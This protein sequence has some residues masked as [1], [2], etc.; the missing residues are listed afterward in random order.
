MYPLC[1]FYCDIKE[2]DS[3]CRFIEAKVDDGMEAVKVLIEFV[4]KFFFMNPDG[5][6]CHESQVKKWVRVEKI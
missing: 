4:Q 5:E 1:D 6:N 2:V 3:F